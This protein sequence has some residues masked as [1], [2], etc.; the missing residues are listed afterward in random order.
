MS[1]HYTGAPR[2]E[3]QTPE[4]LAADMAANQNIIIAS[5]AAVAERAANPAATPAVAEVSAPVAAE[6]PAPRS[7][8]HAAE[9]VPRR[10]GE[11][12]RNVLSKIGAVRGLVGR[13][14]SKEAPV[15]EV[16]DDMAAN[17]R[18]VAGLR[19]EAEA[20][21]APAEEGEFD[22]NQDTSDLSEQVAEL[23]RRQAAAEEPAGRGRRH[24]QPGFLARRRARRAA[25]QE[26]EAEMTENTDADEYAEEVDPFFAEE[27]GEP[28][29]APADVRNHR[30]QHGRHRRAGLLSGLR[31]RRATRAQAEAE[32]DA[33]EYSMLRDWRNWG[34]AGIAAAI[35]IKAHGFRESG[36]ASRVYARLPERGKRVV[37]GMNLGSI[38][39]L[40]GAAWSGV[41]RP[42]ISAIMAARGYGELPGG[43]GS[44]GVL[45]AMQTSGGNGNHNMQLAANVTDLTA[46]NGGNGTAALSGAEH[47]YIDPSHI[48]AQGAMRIEKGE[49]WYHEF[50]QMGMSHDQ[51]VDFLNKHG[52]ELEQRGLA[53]KMGDH[54]WGMNLGHHPHHD[55]SGTYNNFSAD[56][57]KW[58]HDTAVKDGLLPPDQLPDGGTGT[59][60]GT[61]SVD[62]GHPGG[63]EN[64]GHGTDVNGNGNGNNAGLEPAVGNQPRHAAADDYE[65]PVGWTV[66]A[67]GMNAL[68][69]LT[70]Y[71]AGRGA[72]ES[73][74][75]R[76]RRE[77]LEGGRRRAPEAD[78][79]VAESAATEAR[80]ADD[81]ARR[82][83]ENEED[84]GSRS[85][86][87]RRHR[88]PRV[89]LRDRLTGTHV[90]RR[91]AR[92]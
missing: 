32:A 78:Q 64:G 51:A 4:Q 81:Q 50:Q 68:A 22:W 11:R 18:I 82:E 27:T 47:H 34:P 5:R 92:A 26:G 29:A 55:A 52:A 62:G 75:A 14:G 80:E 40:A 77:G 79:V 8:R 23:G 53:Y 76:A 28:A 41:V 45:E 70:G 59:G 69:G 56:D 19:G 74:L 13:R 46:G 35:T 16:A 7:H 39:M 24:R 33:R 17:S 87:V 58:F 88:G 6:A 84:T 67:A 37:A 31:G 54:S 1:E 71:A 86:D 61:G 90:G 20:E 10:R 89:R 57:A 83:D 60:T 15:D 38:A 91:R 3:Q 85:S 9:V 42:S 21:A 30:R 2:G 43:H 48:D 63:T 66:A 73:A 12:V 72:V 65:F 25:A 49:G 36:E 44:T